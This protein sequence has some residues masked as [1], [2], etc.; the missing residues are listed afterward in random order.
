LAGSI[1]RD[2]KKYTQ[3]GGLEKEQINSSAHLGLEL[4]RNT[5]HNSFMNLPMRD[6]S[7]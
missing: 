6:G 4:C 5:S 7:G 2:L 3:Q 1:L